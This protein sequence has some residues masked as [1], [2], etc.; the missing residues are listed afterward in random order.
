[1]S[2]GSIISSAPSTQRMLG[3]SGPRLKEKQL[4]PYLL[5]LSIETFSG[6]V[7][8]GPEREPEQNRDGQVIGHPTI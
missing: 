3:L 8:Q 6:A 4:G 5:F 2:A 7:I 1:M